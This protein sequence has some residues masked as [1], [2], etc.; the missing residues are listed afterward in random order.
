MTSITDG[1]IACTAGRNCFGG[2]RVSFTALDGD[3]APLDRS[4]QHAL[5]HR[6][7]LA[8]R[9]VADARALELGAEASDRLRRQ[10]TQLQVTEAI[11]RVTVPQLRVGAQR[12]ALEVRTRVDQPPLLDELG[13]RLGAGVELGERTAALHHSH[14]GLPGPGVGGT[15]ERLAALGA[16]LVAPARSPHGVDRAVATS[17]FAP[18]NHRQPRDRPARRASSSL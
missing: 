17:P 15:V 6:H 2:L 7:R 3:A 12:R 11:E 4:L 16:S 18:F 9:L 13:Q 10:L 1:G 5:D 14:L 8:D